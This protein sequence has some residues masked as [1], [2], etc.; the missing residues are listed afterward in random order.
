[1][2]NHPIADPELDDLYRRDMEDDYRR[3]QLLD[4]SEPASTKT[5]PGPRLSTGHCGLGVTSSRPG[6]TRTQDHS[7]RNPRPV[8][9]AG[10][11]D[12]NGPELHAT[13]IAPAPLTRP[14]A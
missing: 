7:A 1:M 12:T 6:V 11:C 4:A 13:E 14:G 9:Q 5:T 10:A 2:A 8:R 3:D